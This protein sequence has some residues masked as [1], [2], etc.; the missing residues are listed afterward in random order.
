MPAGFY[1]QERTVTFIYALVSMELEASL[2]K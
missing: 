2:V 1:Q